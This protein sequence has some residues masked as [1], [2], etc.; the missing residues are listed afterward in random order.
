[1]TSIGTR[2]ETHPMDARSSGRNRTA[3]RGEPGPPDPFDEPESDPPIGV[4]MQLLR[5]VVVTLGS[6]ALLAVLVLQFGRLQSSSYFRYFGVNVS[7]LDLT[8]NDFLVA[9][10]EGLLAPAITICAVVLGLSLLHRFVLGRLSAAHR[11]A[12]LRGLIPL[13]GSLGAILVTLAL[14]DLLGRSR[15]LWSGSAIGGLALA[16][17]TLCVVYAA[18][19]ARLAAPLWR[20]SS[21]PGSSR[22]PVTAGLAEWGSAILLVCLGLLWSVSNYAF[23][24]GV[25]RATVL[26]RALAVQPAVVLF[27]QHRMS[28]HVAGVTEDKCHDPQ[29]AYG[30]RYDGLRLIRQTGDQYLLLPA[31]WTRAKGTVLLVPRSTTVRLELRNS[32]VAGLAC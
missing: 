29:A 7:L 14:F 24:T 4:P 2:R 30:F 16:V 31:N 21:D 10:A 20:G 28:L 8:P 27:S 5:I 26:H 6:A 3:R 25:G 1:M 13:A 12:V 15:L 11:R 18:R 23:T 32:K 22:R 19:Q 17:G 9:G